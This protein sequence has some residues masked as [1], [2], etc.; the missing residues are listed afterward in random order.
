M[1][2]QVNI[3]KYILTVLLAVF[4]LFTVMLL[5]VGKS[6]A[7]AATMSMREA[8]EASNVMDDLKGST[9][10][11]KPFDLKDYGF[12]ANKYTTVFSFVEYCYSFDP[13]RQGDFGLYVYVYNPQGINFKVNSTQ[14]KIQ[15]G[16][17]DRRETYR[18]YPIKFLN[19]ST[20]TNYFGL[21]I[22]YKVELTDS[23]RQDILDGLNSTERVYEVSGIELLTYGESNA[24]DYPATGVVDER[25][26]GSKIYRYSGY[27]KG[28]GADVTT[29]SLE[30]SCAEGDVLRLEVHHTSYRQKGVTNGKDEYTQD[31]LNSVYFAVPKKIADK[32]G[33][34]SEVHA[35][36]RNAITAWA[37]VTGNYEIYSTFYN[38]VGKR[39]GNNNRDIGYSVF[40][41]PVEVH[42]TIDIPTTISES[43]VAYNARHSLSTDGT[44]TVGKTMECRNYL[45]Q[46]NWLFNASTETE[47]DIADRTAISSKKLYDWYVT[48]FAKA[49]GKDYTG[50]TLEIKDGVK[51]YKALFDSVDAEI[52]DY[53]I[54]ADEK[55]TLL[56][57]K[58]TQSWWEEHVTGGHHKDG[59]IGVGAE[60][61]AI[62]EV[63]DDDILSDEKLTCER[64]YISV[65]DYEEFI[66]YYN[67][68]KTEN[69]IYLIRL[70][71]T[72]YSSIE[73]SQ[74]KYSSNLFGTVY[75]KKLDTNGYFFKETALLD[76]DIIDVT[77]DNGQITT[78]IPCVSD[79]V[80]IFSEATP[81]VHTNSDKDGLNFL[82]KF[83]AALCRGE[84]WAVTITVI[85][86]LIVL[87]VLIKL[88]S[89][90]FPLFATIWR[91]IKKGL[92]WALS[93][94]WW[95]IKQP[96]I[97]I[98]KLAVKLKARAAERKERKKKLRQAKL[99]RKEALQISRY[100][101]KLLRKEQIYREKIEAKDNKKAAKQK[102]KQ[103]A[104]AARQQAKAEKKTAAQNAKAKKQ[105]E[106]KR[107]KAAA[108]RKKAKAKAKP[109]QKRKAPQN[110]KQ[111]T[112][113]AKAGKTK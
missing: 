89:L 18:K 67:L 1:K 32:Y 36:W 15:L 63:T 75:E 82:Q 38:Y 58:W 84:W 94:V 52:K 59:N 109:A 80:D 99:A 54:K 40:G 104:K 20:D 30:V 26:K 10:D 107:R 108:K 97:A 53:R 45:T 69:Y 64:L 17:A 111:K 86:G 7:H 34:L 85:V 8:Y 13:A 35:E 39:I 44:I 31:N 33:Y 29:D 50:E 46:L 28:W 88:L 106:Q 3:I 49:V 66:N 48:D 23:Q 9:V 92:K 51:I 60:V 19:S 55:H 91:G 16:I 73:A 41:D 105:A 93:G 25:S 47:Q 112:N 4:T 57:Q 79:P 102:A 42:Y 12:N 100:Q 72:D 70:G 56:A 95:L 77:F 113:N 103:D 37:L 98:K 110:G 83:W 27:S 74:Y 6:T 11:G 5:N 101:N 62:H 78:V 96:F 21:F 61:E 24:H 65:S 71:V 22:K 76:F 81:P 87:A 2:R 90:F 14:N 68:N 43:E